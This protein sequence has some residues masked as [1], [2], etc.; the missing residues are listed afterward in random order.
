MV[1]Y[2]H[3]CG[4]NKEVKELRY[5]KYIAERTDELSEKINNISIEN[6]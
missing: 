6:L 4:I 2:I 5:M 1:V 3:N